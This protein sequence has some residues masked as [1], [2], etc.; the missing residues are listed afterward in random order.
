M[1]I[2]IDYVEF[3]NDPRYS[4][5]STLLDKSVLV[6]SD[7][8]T[9]KALLLNV[10]FGSVSDSFVLADDDNTY[11][12]DINLSIGTMLDSDNMSIPYP[13][14]ITSE[15]LLTFA[16]YDLSGHLIKPNDLSKY[17]ND[18]ESSFVSEFSTVQ[19]S[20][21]S[22]ITAL[23]D[24]LNIAKSDLLSYLDGQFSSLNFDDS[25]IISTLDDKFLAFNSLLAEKILSLSSSFDNISFSSLNG[26]GGSYK[27]GTE[28]VVSGVTGI[29]KVVASQFLKNDENQYIIV[30]KLEKDGSYSLFPSVMV[31]VSGG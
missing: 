19:T 12:F 30:Y 14:F 3:G 1:K 6:Y 17:F 29:F 28:V 16:K 8:G 9:T 21:S 24:D 2:V 4:N 25:N 31:S 5:F 23:A 26:V 22:D 20:L 10:P 15:Y 27:D 13:V 7:D 11:F 18:L